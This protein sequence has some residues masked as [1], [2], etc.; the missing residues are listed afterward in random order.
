[1][2]KIAKRLFDK[3]ELTTAALRDEIHRKTGTKF[4]LSYVRR[5]LRKFDFTAKLP[6]TVHA[7]AASD[8]ECDEW[9][10]RT[11]RRIRYFRERGFEIGIQDEAIISESGKARRKLWVPRG[12]K[13]R[14]VITGRRNK[15][16]LYGVLFDN[17]DQMFRFK[18][19]FNGDAF[20]Q[21]LRELLRKKE[22][23]FLIVDGARQHFT[24]KVKAFLR[25]NKKRLVLC[26]L[27]TASPHMS[28]MEKGW[29]ILR[30]A[31]EARRSYASLAEKVADMSK[32]V[33]TKRFNLD[34]YAYLARR[35]E[36][37]KYI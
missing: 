7:D 12:L 30:G 23:V 29:S 13:L 15:K 37:G 27:P 14:V 11:M 2:K 25:E 31:T 9:F 16:I 22:K 26:T 33:R 17:G 4:H 35:L 5:T 3:G 36:A 20:L 34:M 24:K 21:F 10:R 6:D 8:D 19:K 1:M 32:Y 18:D 28:I